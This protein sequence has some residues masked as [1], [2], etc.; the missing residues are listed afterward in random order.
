[1][2]LN[3]QSKKTNIEKNKKKN[4]ESDNPF[5]EI[6]PN[7]CIL[8]LCLGL[9]IFSPFALNKLEDG[10]FQ[11]LYVVVLSSTVHSSISITSSYCSLLI[12]HIEQYI[13]RFKRLTGLTIWQYF[14]LT[15]RQPSI[16]IYRFIVRVEAVR[17]NSVLIFLHVK[18]GFFS[19]VLLIAKIPK[20]EIRHL[21]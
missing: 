8:R 11:F 10:L 14:V 3:V 6:P 17:T 12:L 9:P 16:L 7:K 2:F 19:R 15:L 18:N 13:N 1:M 21:D 4:I 5:L 20:E